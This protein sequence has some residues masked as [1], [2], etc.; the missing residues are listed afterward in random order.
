MQPLATIEIHMVAPR[1][2]EVV[3]FDRIIQGTFDRANRIL[4]GIQG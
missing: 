1:I 4:E 3:L 2:T